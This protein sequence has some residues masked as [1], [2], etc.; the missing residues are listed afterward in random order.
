M[1]K[2]PKV[3]FPSVTQR[4]VE[5][6][7]VH[8]WTFSPVSV[9]EFL[10]IKKILTTKWFFVFEFTFKCQIRKEGIV[11]FGVYSKNLQESFLWVSNLGKGFFSRLFR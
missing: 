5:N 10:T 9:K 1:K 2:I 6:T 3:I 11:M 8:L 7:R 4:R